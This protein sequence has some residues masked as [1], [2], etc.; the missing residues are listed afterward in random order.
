MRNPTEVKPLVT[1]ALQGLTP[2]QLAM[3]A[4]LYAKGWDGR[5]PAPAAMVE[6]C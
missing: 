2:S 3:A 5:N 4:E 6:T 1:S